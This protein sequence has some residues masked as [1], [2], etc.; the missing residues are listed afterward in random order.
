MREKTTTAPAP[1]LL[2]PAVLASLR[3]EPSAVLGVLVF[4]AVTGFWCWRIQRGVDLSDESLYVA[5]P[6]RFVLGDR[7]FLDDRTSIQGAGLLEV[8][9]VAAYH[10]VVRSNAGLM[11]FMRAAYLAFLSAI[12]LTL[13]SAVRGWISRGAAL[14][15]G[16]L[17]CFYAPYSIFQFSYNTVGGGMVILA[18]IAVLRLARGDLSTRSAARW[19]MLAGASTAS[20]MLAYPTLA[21]VVLFHAVT[22]V[23]FGNK[24]LGWWRVLAWYT[25][26]GAAIGLYVCLFL[27]RSGFGSL[28]LTVDFV[29]AYGPSLTKELSTVPTTIARFKNDWVHAIAVA[30]TL[31]A[32]ARRIRPAVFLL[33]LWLPT[34]ALPTG[35]VE[36]T[37]PMCFFTCIALFAP[38]FAT[39]VDDRR[40]A[41]HVLAILWAPGMVVGVLT[42]ISSSNGALASGLG[43]FACLLAGYILACRACE[44]AWSRPWRSLLGWSSIVAPGAVLVTLLKLASADG[45]VYRD[46]PLSQLTHRVRSGPFRGLKTTPQHKQLVEQMHADVVA[47][48]AG[49]RY[50]L[51]FPD[52]PSAYLSA[53]TRG[54][55]A[56]IWTGHVQERNRI[57]A[58]LFREK[59]RDVGIVG[60]RTCPGDF[61]RSC[62]PEGFATRN[63][64]L[65][66]AVK[67][68]HEVVL[69]RPDYALLKPRQ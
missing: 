54:A 46:A 51:F 69:R 32:L 43:G 13:A 20:A 17:V 65:V 6:L 29:R 4:V 50:G 24:P 40:R 35:I 12:G 5:L 16:A 68:T 36:Y 56:E 39:L 66:Q 2:L 18:S 59:A 15:C 9:L 47:H 26:G 67:E 10:L 62:A 21:P 53:N 22:I 57:D 3:R 64:P 45:A 28:K 25:A 30:V 37:R 19:A 7:P 8:P 34:L 31:T 55:V 52:M 44:E 14:A 11:L 58:E 38:L 49:A 63:N 23:V 27:L 48:A 33:A 61:W 60:M 41:F 42:G 1:P